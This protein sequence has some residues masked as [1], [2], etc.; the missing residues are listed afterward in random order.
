MVFFYWMLRFCASILRMFAARNHKRAQAAYDQLDTSFRDV[1]SEC[2]SEEVA[3]GRPLDYIAQI[4]LLK[5]YEELEDARKTWVKSA[6]RLKTRE[7]FAKNLREFSGRKVPYLF[8]L[9]DM[10]L[11]FKAF[12]MVQSGQINLQRIADS[13]GSI[14]G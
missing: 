13:I 1:E 2:K 3:V 4:K 11:A 10:A 9:V 8:G 6:N 14:F 5:G 7:K 12:D